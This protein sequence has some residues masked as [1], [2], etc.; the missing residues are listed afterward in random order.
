MASK[1]EIAKKRRDE[2][3]RRNEIMMKRIEKNK[4]KKK[5]ESRGEIAKKKSEK[6]KNQPK[7]KK[8]SLITKLKNLALGG[9]SA[10]AK[11]V[12]PKIKKKPKQD[13]REANK[14]AA[15][16]TERM[17][18][19]KDSQVMKAEKDRRARAKAKAAKKAAD[20]KAA[21]N[22]DAKR[23]GF[24]SANAMKSSAKKANKAQ[25]DRKKKRDAELLSR[26]RR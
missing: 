12:K 24:I 2:N 20:K 22:R 10:Q 4:Q 18:K 19:A 7:K 14:K 11:E 17:P 16:V 13:S 26:G 1:A 21:D 25:A 5:S 3:K 15:G 23:G 8:E 6:N 9:G